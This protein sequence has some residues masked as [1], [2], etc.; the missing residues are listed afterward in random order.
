MWEVQWEDVRTFTEAESSQKDEG[1]GRKGVVAVGDEV[2]LGRSWEP[3]SAGERPLT[4]HSKD[5]SVNNAY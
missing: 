4:I 5:D 2:E 1:R 3:M